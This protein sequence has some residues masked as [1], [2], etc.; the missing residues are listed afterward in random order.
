MKYIKFG[1][2]IDCNCLN[3]RNIPANNTRRSLPDIPSEQG[4]AV[5]WEPAG[6][7]SSEH[8]A[9][10]GQFQ[11]GTTWLFRNLLQFNTNNC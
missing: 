2:K 5:N 3:Y 4:T 10:V 6:D 7:N 11:N 8:Y 1:R 9:T